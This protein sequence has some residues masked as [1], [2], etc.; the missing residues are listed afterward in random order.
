M[1]DFDSYEKSKLGGISI[2]MENATATD[3][4]SSEV[5]ELCPRC[6]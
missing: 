5:I 1:G 6:V 2:N 4:D 3:E